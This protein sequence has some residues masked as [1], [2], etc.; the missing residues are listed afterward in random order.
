MLSSITSSDNAELIIRSIYGS[1]PDADSPLYPDY[2][3][4][5]E[6]QS[7]YMAAKMSE[8]GIK[9]I[10]LGDYSAEYSDESLSSSSD[11]ISPYA[12]AVLDN[13]YRRLRTAEVIF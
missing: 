4:A 13:I 2:L 3:K 6:L 12:A 9:K 11:I 7:D 1:P 10:S 5:V 8:Q